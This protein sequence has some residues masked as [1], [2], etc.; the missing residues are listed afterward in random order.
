MTPKWLKVTAITL[1]A[2][3]G[4]FIV[5]LLV[6]V[7]KHSDSDYEEHYLWAT[8]DEK[9]GEKIPNADFVVAPDNA[10]QGKIRNFSSRDAKAVSIVIGLYDESG[11][12][13]LTCVDATMGV[14]GGG[15]VGIQRKMYKRYNCSSKRFCAYR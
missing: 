6:F 7:P 12:K 4:I 11:V 15:N 3:L 5:V 14:K 8:W 10:F 13:Y 2:I 9:S 1:V